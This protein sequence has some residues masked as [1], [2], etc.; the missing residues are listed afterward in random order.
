[1]RVGADDGD[2]AA[3]S[4]GGQSGVERSLESRRSSVPTTVFGPRLGPRVAAYIPIQIYLRNQRAPLLARS[5]DLGI[6]GVCVATSTGFPIREVDRVSI[7]FPR[8]ALA[9]PARGCWQRRIEDEE[10]ISSGIEFLDCPLEVRSVL[11]EIMQR[12]AHEIACFLEESDAPPGLDLDDRIELAKFSRLRQIPSRRMIYRA[13]EREAESLFVVF[14]GSV[15]LHAT[16]EPSL[17]RIVQQGSCFGGR[18]LLA[19]LPSVDSCL[20]REDTQ[21]LEVDVHAYRFLE[22]ARPILAR[23]ILH[24]ILQWTLAETAR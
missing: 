5:R 17:G 22:F 3:I 20:A 8:G 15:A 23:R 12:R 19:D 14:R 21:L 7:E 9:S 4:A 6:G 11:A 10:A 16:G 18:S 1:M 13:S 2:Q 24:A